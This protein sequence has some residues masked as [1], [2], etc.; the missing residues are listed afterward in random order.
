MEDLDNILNEMITMSDYKNRGQQYE[1]LKKLFG[2]GGSFNKKQMLN[3]FINESDKLLKNMP[4]NNPLPEEMIIL[5]QAMW[6]SWM[7]W[8]EKMLFAAPDNLTKVED[9]E[10]KYKEGMYYNGRKPGVVI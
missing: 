3:A 7:T 1:A 2:G 5:K 8:F 6:S 4:N 10:E 9:P